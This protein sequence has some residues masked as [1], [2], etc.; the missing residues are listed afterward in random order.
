MLF[1]SVDDILTQEKVMVYSMLCIYTAYVVHF[2][3]ILMVLVMHYL[4]S[5]KLVSVCTLHTNT[6]QI[7]LTIYNVCLIPI[8]ANS[9]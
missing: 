6:L 2:F 3:G 9:I 1:D 4:A 5:Y 7:I 8:S